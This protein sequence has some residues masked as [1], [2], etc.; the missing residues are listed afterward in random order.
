[1]SKGHGLLFED[2]RKGGGGFTSFFAVSF[3]M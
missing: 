2:G 1:M 3:G